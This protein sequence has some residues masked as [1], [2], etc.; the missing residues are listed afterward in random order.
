MSEDTR[1]RLV[2]AACS[3]AFI[4]TVSIIGIIARHSG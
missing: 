1:N 4:V 3:T 2:V